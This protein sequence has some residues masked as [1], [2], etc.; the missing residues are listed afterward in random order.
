MRNLKLFFSALILSCIA[1]PAMAIDQAV[2]TFV[3]TATGL[4]TTPTCT[5]KYRVVDRI[6][7]IICEAGI[8]GTSNTTAFTI[9]GV[10]AKARPATTARC[11]NVSVTD[12]TGKVPG[13]ACISTT[14]TITFGMG[15]ALSA[16]GFTNSGTKAI[17]AGFS[18]TYPID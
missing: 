16:T 10:P 12:N 8:T 7:T 9:T 13:E 17:A 11:R 3:G 15:A 14:G 4:T 1:L 6:V 2:G 5:F 18:L